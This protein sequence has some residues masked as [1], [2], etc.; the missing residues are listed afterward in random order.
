MVLIKPSG[1][2][3]LLLLLLDD[4]DD[5]DDDIVEAKS[6][7]WNFG[8]LGAVVVMV[9]GRVNPWTGAKEDDDRP[10]MNIVIMHSIIDVNGDNAP[11]VS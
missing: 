5:D 6:R 4:D 11:A 8:P 2:F 3:L 9:V 7:D 10:M 1:R